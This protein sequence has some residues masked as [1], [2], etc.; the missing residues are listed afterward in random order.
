[1]DNILRHAHFSGPAYTA[2]HKLDR[3]RIA[4]LTKKKWPRNTTFAADGIG[5]LASV[6][7]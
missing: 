3:T 7:E 6:L 2:G 1:L 5:L 4:Q